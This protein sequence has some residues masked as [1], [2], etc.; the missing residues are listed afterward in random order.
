MSDDGSEAHSIPEEALIWPQ[1]L[2]SLRDLFN[3]TSEVERD[4][5]LWI[6]YCLIRDW[7]GPLPDLRDIFRREEIDLLLTRSAYYMGNPDDYDTPGTRFYDF[8]IRSGYRNEPDL[9]ENGEPLLCRTT[10]IHIAAKIWSLRRDVPVRELF[11]IYDKFDANYAD[12]AGYTHFHVACEYGFDDVVEKFLEA[13]QDPDC[14]GSRYD[15][16]PLHLAL[17]QKYEETVKL[18]LTRGADPNLADAEGSTAL[19]VIARRGDLFYDEIADSFFGTSDEMGRTLRIDARDKLG[20]TPLHRATEL[21]YWYLVKSLLGR[22]ADPNAANEEGWT[23]LHLISKREQSYDDDSARRFFEI[24]DEF[25]RTTVRID[26]K[27]KSGRTP[28]QLAVANLAPKNV[29]VLLDRGADLTDF[30]FPAEIRHFNRKYESDGGWVLYKLIQACNAMIVVERLQKA[31]Y[32]LHRND[33]LTIMKFFAEHGLFHESERRPNPRSYK[34]KKFAD[35]AKEITIL[36]SL[37]LYD[38]VR[39]RGSPAPDEAAAKP[40]EYEDYHELWRSRKLRQLPKRGSYRDVCARHLC[41]ILS[42]GFFRRWALDGLSELTRFE[43]PTHC[44]EIV[45]ENSTNEDLWRIC[46]AAAQLAEALK[47]LEP[48]MSPREVADLLCRST[49]AAAAAARPSHV[50][51]WEED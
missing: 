50:L 45:V 43:L 2:K 26:A 41:E 42:R 32:R 27:D 47:I 20:D 5:F 13:G 34:D 4:C 9:D 28:L 8:V 6:V 3:W 22:G 21:G 15:C 7:K 31:G 24:N 23:P 18:L 48:S 1:I 44:C 19:H 29:G 51:V 11:K 46:L 49:T 14:L 35:V 39:S 17:L 16:P 37:S 10:P 12:E 33:A 30:I 25:D 36:P 40:L 38:F